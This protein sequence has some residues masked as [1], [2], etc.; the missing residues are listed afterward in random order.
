MPHTTSLIYPRS[1]AYFV[2]QV[3]AFTVTA[4]CGRL[5]QINLPPNMKFTISGQSTAMHR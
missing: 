2:S 3:F 1:I 4:Q 5:V